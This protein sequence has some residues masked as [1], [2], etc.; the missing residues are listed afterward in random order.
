MK[1]LASI[2]ICIIHLVLLGCSSN[3]PHKS[4]DLTPKSPTVGG[5]VSTMPNPS[6][7]ASDNINIIIPD[8]GS[9]NKEL[10][11]IFNTI[12][13]TA[14]DNVDLEALN[15]EKLNSTVVIVRNQSFGARDTAVGQDHLSSQRYLRY[16]IRENRGYIAVC[17]GAT[18]NDLG[19]DAVYSFSDAFT[20]HSE[21]DP[22]YFDA[23][24]IIYNN[25]VVSVIG[26]A[27]EGNLDVET[28]ISFREEVVDLLEVNLI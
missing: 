10:D 2:I 28:V 9:S 11:E 18:R 8:N 14:Y 22:L 13:N 1:R 16:K 23:L 25:Y 15:Y 19:K 24:T 6:T 20:N 26:Y 27:P 4:T 12:A 21:T 17:I 3:E 7:D 5:E